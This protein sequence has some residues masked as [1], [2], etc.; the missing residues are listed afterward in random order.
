MIEIHFDY[1]D[2][3]EISIME[4]LEKGDNFTTHCLEFFSFD[5][6][7]DVI[8]KNKE[9]KQIRLSEINKHCLKEIGET[10][11]V[12]KMLLDNLFEWIS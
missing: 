2:G 11:N 8:V 10:Y 12:R 4:G 3:T 5:T 9:G 1:T 7:A 6:K